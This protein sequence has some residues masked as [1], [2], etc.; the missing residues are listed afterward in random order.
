MWLWGEGNSGRREVGFRVFILN[1]V[2][3]FLFVLIVKCV[4]K[5]LFYYRVL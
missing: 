3:L 1:V 5:I 2:V 4:Y